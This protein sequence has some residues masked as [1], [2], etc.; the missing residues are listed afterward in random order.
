MYKILPALLLSLSACALANTTPHWSYE[1]KGGPENWGD[2]SD[3]FVTCKT[4]KFQSPVDIHNTIDAKLPPLHLD[5]HTVAETL[6]NNGHS[7]QITVDDEDD[8]QL[9]NETFVLRQYHF[10]APSENMI[11]GKR[12]P[13]EAHFVH[14]NDKG[15]IAVLAVMFTVGAE[16][17]ALTPIIESIPK[18]KNRV[19]PVAKRFDMTPLF[20][21]DL[22]YYRFSGSLTTPPCTEGVRWLVLKDTVTLSREQL[23]AFQKALEHNNNRPVQP[24]DGRMIVK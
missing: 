2:L 23:S 11:D 1:G 8:F 4:G 21:A 24:I 5:F 18:E 10:H 3:S 7:I 6:V 17:S 20:P 12:Y 15:E 13:L 14:T 22:H 19:V 9:D 16:N